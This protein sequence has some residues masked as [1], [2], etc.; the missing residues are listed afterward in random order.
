MSAK[1]ATTSVTILIIQGVFICKKH[2]F[3]I[4][5]T[6]YSLRVRIRIKI[7]VRDKS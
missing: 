4:P 3:R 2:N 5:Y 7:R 1:W 6:P